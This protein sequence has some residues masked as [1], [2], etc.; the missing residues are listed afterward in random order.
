M[1]NVTTDVEKK[2]KKKNKATQQFV[3]VIER[4]SSGGNW[5]LY[6]T[7]F[8]TS[9]T[10]RNKEEKNKTILQNRHPKPK[11]HIPI[12]IVCTY[13]VYVHVYLHTYEYY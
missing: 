13:I 6:K 2:K 3:P 7:L 12:H 10:E 11:R 8:S 1:D 9:N 5:E 4:K